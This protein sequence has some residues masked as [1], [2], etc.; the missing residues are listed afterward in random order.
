MHRINSDFFRGDSYVCRCSRS[1]ACVE[2]I[3]RRPQTRLPFQSQQRVPICTR[4]VL[5]KLAACVLAPS[6]LDRARGIS[7]LTPESH[8]FG[9]DGARSFQTEFAPARQYLDRFGEQPL[10]FGRSRRRAASALEV[11]TRPQSC[12]DPRAN[13]PRR[14]RVGIRRDRSQSSDRH[15]SYTGHDLPATGVAVRNRSTAD[16]SSAPR[17]RDHRMRASSLVGQS[18]L[19]QRRVD[20]SHAAV[21][22]N[23]QRTHSLDPFLAPAPGFNVIDGPRGMRPVRT[24][25][26]S[27][28]HRTFRRA[29][30]PRAGHG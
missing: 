8:D 13:R 11:R 14:A 17:A 18:R 28:E 22:G 7:H 10:P 23:E 1:F 2:S 3:Q 26:R 9:H 20:F 5:A 12:F 27:T 30:R 6:L 24:S 25:P 4:S 16:S 21:L 19:S 15:A 29:P